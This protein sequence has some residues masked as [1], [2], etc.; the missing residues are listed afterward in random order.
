MPNNEKTLRCELC[1]YKPLL[2]TYGVDKTGRLYVHVKVYKG[3]RI[4]GNIYA[5]GAVKLQC[6]DCL[7]WHNVQITQPDHAVLVEEKVA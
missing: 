6:R 1:T 4:F 2:A 7:R 5:S 3:D